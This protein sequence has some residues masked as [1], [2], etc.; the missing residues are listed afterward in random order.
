MLWRASHNAIPTLCNLQRRNVVQVTLYSRCKLGNEDI[1]HALWSCPC[2][3][4]VWSKDDELIKLLRYKFL[5]FSDLLGMAFSMRDRI[6]LNLL[7]I[8]FWL[9]WTKRNSDKLGEAFVDLC[10]IRTKVMTFFHE[11]QTTLPP[12]NWVQALVPQVV[13]WI[14]PI[15][16]SL[17]INFDGA[18]S[19]EIGIAR[20]YRCCSS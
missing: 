4:A 14:P 8:C 19:N 17:K 12:Q 7:V 10:R 6:Y 13:R 11:F 5:Q 16:P 1:I 3:F 9:I 15:S 2:L 18:T 20:I